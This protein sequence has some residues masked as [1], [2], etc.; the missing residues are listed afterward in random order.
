MRE[1]CAL[2]LVIVVDVGIG[3]ATGANAFLLLLLVMLPQFLYL[4]FISVFE[5]C[6]GVGGQTRFCRFDLE[7]AGSN[8]N[9]KAQSS[10]LWR[11]CRMLIILFVLWFYKF[12]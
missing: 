3:M 4:D 1:A 7:L 8:E 10:K 12:F 9:A 6:D 5:F 11:V 2:V